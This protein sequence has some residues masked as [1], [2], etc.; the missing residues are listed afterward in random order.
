MT[1]RK[2]I[3]KPSSMAPGTPAIQNASRQPQAAPMPTMISGPSSGI[4]CSPMVE[5]SPTASPRFS[6]DTSLLTIW[7]VSGG[8]PPSASP[9]SARAA[10]S[11][12]IPT[13]SPELIEA[14]EKI[15]VAATS[16]SLARPV[17]SAARVSPK[18]DSDHVTAS[19]PLIRPMCVLVRWNSGWI[20]GA[21][22]PNAVRSRNTMPRLTPSSPTNRP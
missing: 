16:S 1:V 15:T 21:S 8:S 14:S 18:L 5:V 13:A 7:N 11:V 3:K 2:K 20:I 19:T 9:I 22:S 6:A 12:S 17:R 4:A 10:I